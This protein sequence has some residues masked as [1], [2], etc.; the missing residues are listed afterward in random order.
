MIKGCVWFHGRW[1]SELKDQILDTTKNG[2]LEESKHQV[3]TVHTRVQCHPLWIQMSR[4][5]WELFEIVIVKLI[6]VNS[7]N[8]SATKRLQRTWRFTGEIVQILQ[9]LLL[10][11]EVEGKCVK[12][13]RQV[14]LWDQDLGWCCCHGNPRLISIKEKRK[15][16]KSLF[17]FF[18]PFHS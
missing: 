2:I 5:N 6:L 16:S 3:L 10:P 12:G 4:L 7:V 1:V 9:D 11:G 15:H 14:Y 18:W 17:T 13:V 8:V